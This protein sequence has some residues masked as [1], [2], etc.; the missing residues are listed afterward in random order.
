MY[1]FTLYVHCQRH[2]KINFLEYSKSNFQFKLFF[3]MERSKRSGRI[4]GCPVLLDHQHVSRSPR[5]LHGWRSFLA[6]IWTVVEGLSIAARPAVMPNRIGTV[7]IT[8]ADIEAHLQPAI[9]VRFDISTCY[10]SIKRASNI[11]RN[12]AKTTAFRA[13]FVEIG[14]PAPGPIWP[15]TDR[16]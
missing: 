3:F 16:A 6:A 9:P 4:S 12:A 8:S 2:Q 11:V 10:A 13:V 5:I 15:A 1:H 7:G 14:S